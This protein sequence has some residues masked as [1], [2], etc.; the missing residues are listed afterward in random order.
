MPVILLRIE[1]AA[2]LA[3]AIVAYA[4]SGQSWLLFAALVL[5]PDISM[6]GYLAGP[7]IGAHCYNAAHITVW[8]LAI[9]VAGYFSA[10]P[11]LIG[12]GLIWLAHIGIDRTLGYGLKHAS[13]F[14][15][16]HLGRIGR[17]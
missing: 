9:V 5:V 17:S 13:D 16:T 2:L 15:D 14:R 1:G 10:A 12:I 11:T 4:M 3:A 7:R 8:P 6:L